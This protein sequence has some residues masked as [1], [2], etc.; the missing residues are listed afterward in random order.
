MV[1]MFINDCC[2]R[3][4]SLNSLVINGK[5]CKRMK[6][7]DSL[8]CMSGVVVVRSVDSDEGD[9]ST[10]VW[11]TLHSRSYTSRSYKRALFLYYFHNFPGV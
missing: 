1:S 4:I 3:I 10:V 2:I 6:D 5:Q 7:F 9:S 11:C 8:Y